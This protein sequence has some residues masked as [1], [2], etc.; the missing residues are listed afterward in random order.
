M[1]IVAKRKDYYDCIQAYMQD[2]SVVYVREPME[3]D[4]VAYY[5]KL[6]PHYFSIK[7]GGAYVIGF[8]GKL[9]P[10]I[11]MLRHEGKPG[12]MEYIREAMYNIDDLD[13]YFE[14]HCSKE[15]KREYWNEKSKKWANGVNRV[16][17]EKFFNRVNEVSDKF[18]EWFE[19]KRCPIFSMYF[20]DYNCTMIYNDMLNQF[21]FFKVFPPHDAFQNIFM[22]MS[23]LAVPQK[24]MPQISDEMKIATHGFTKD[25][26]R[27]SS[28]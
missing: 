16:S 10:C 21:Q 28:K 12:S 8:C 9:Y 24:P 3:I 14:K 22:F 5:P 23:N 25:S 26:F 17:Y 11:Q 13:A 2:R 15:A 18:P 6:F 19:E 20:S 7:R 1:R 27:S 4:K